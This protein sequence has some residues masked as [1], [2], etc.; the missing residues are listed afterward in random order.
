MRDLIAWLKSQGRDE[1]IG[2]MQAYWEQFGVK[3]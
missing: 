2:R 1:D 3:E